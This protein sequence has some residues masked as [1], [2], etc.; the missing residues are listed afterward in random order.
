MRF[1]TE[2]GTEYILNDIEMVVE[3]TGEECPSVGPQGLPVRVSYTGNLSRVGKPLRDLST[4]GRF[5]AAE[6]FYSI[7]FSNMP[8]VGSRFTYYHPMWAGCYSTPIT[9]ILV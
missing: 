1:S 8:E 4:G 2:S 3:A 6:E 7:E 5:E 9:N